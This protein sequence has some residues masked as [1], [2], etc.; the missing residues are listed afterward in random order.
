M[1]RIGLYSEP[2]N[3]EIKRYSGLYRGN[4]MIKYAKSGKVLSAMLNRFFATSRNGQDVD[5]NETNKKM[6]VELYNSL[7]K[8]N[9]DGD[10]VLFT[11]DGD[12][13][14]PGFS[15]VGY[16]ICADSMYYSPLGDGFLE[17]YNKYPLF[18]SDMPRETYSIYKND[19]NENQLFGSLDVAEAFSNYCNYINK[20]HRYCIEFE[21]NWR[22]VSVKIAF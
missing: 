8:E 3:K 21:D 1:I 14:M 11:D 6:I 17:R 4:E 7:K 9:W 16:D 12:I 2:T 20:K 5:Y 19:L 18:Y 10:L 13:E 22:P 15:F